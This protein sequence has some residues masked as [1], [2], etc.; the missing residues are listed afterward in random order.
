M[1]AKKHNLNN[2]EIIALLNIYNSRKKVSDI[3]N[4]PWST[5]RLYLEKEMYV[6]RIKHINK[7]EKGEVL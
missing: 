2:D 4:V 6:G 7:Y 5:F 1:P 3:L